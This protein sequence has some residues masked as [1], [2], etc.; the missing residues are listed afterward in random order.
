[1]EDG[2]KNALIS[3]DYASSTTAQGENISAI[4]SANNEFFQTILTIEVTPRD[5]KSLFRF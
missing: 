5:H 3:G 4:F 2:D 1:M